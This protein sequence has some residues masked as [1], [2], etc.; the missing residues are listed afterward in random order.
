MMR[1]AEALDEPSA[2]YRGD[3]IVVPGPRRPLL[4]RADRPPEARRAARRPGDGRPCR[5]R[6]RPRAGAAGAQARAVRFRG[7]HPDEPRHAGDDRRAGAGQ[8]LSFPARQRG[9][10]DDR[11]PAGAER[12]ERR[13][14]QAGARRRLSARACLRGDRRSRARTAGDPRPARPGLRRAEGLSRGR[15][16]ADRPPPPLA[17]AQPR[18]GAGRSARRAWGSRDDERRNGRRRS[19]PAPSTTS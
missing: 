10:R 12:E 5:V 14:R 1:I 8:F 6:A 2:A 9:L 7:R 11:R 18:P 16:R 17:D 3:A 13:L 4:G 19:T 15:E